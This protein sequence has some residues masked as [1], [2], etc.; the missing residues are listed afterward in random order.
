[1]WY[2]TK[3]NNSIDARQLYALVGGV[4]IVALIVG[5]TWLVQHGWGFGTS[6]RFDR[7]V[8]SDAELYI[9]VNLRQDQK[10]KLTQLED[11]EQWGR[12]RL[13][14]EERLT[15]QLPEGLS[16]DQLLKVA[17]EEMAIFHL[18]EG[19][20]V[21][22]TTKNDTGAIE[23]LDVGGLRV[24]EIQHN[25]YL[26]ADSDT[27]VARTQAV[28]HKDEV[29][30]ESKVAGFHP[31]NKF[32][33]GFADASKL[34][35]LIFTFD[36]LGLAGDTIFF[37]LALNSTGMSGLLASRPPT[38]T[39]V[40]RAGSAENVFSESARFLP[41]APGLHWT[42]VNLAEMYATLPRLDSFTGLQGTQT[43]PDTLESIFQLDWD[44][45]VVPLLNLP[46]TI[47]Y[48]PGPNEEDEWLLT[49]RPEESRREETLNNLE[50]LIKRV[51]GT[52]HPRRVEKTLTDGTVVTELLP[53][54]QAGTLESWPG[55]ESLKILRLEDPTQT[56]VFG[57]IGSR[58]IISNSKKAAESLLDEKAKTVTNSSCFDSVQ[59][60]SVLYVDSAKLQQSYFGLVGSK[61]L[62]IGDGGKEKSL[63]LTFCAEFG[64]DE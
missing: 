49:L 53:N 36:M 23:R 32:I 64:P 8:P 37:D 41:D 57:N 30:L 40:I 12:F 48:I 22:F 58:L 9:H 60:S 26:I 10:L 59:G 31:N 52:L 55:H 7:V 14:A 56:V 62:V 46:A 28:I 4:L 38:V 45:S 43:W 5:L 39:D 42:N 2:A 44:E 27:V 13:D 51:A 17:D 1:M 25:A 19:R 35:F 18:P 29:S 20:G 61:S 63:Y 21:I 11:N 33:Y 50:A 54:P 15:S 34:R 47:S 6:A 3:N 16:L 24:E